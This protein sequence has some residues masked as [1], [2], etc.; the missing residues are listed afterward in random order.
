M[1]LPLGPTER[2][3]RDEVRAFVRARL[4][5]DIRAKGRDFLALKRDEAVRW[6]KILAEAGWLAP[7]WPKEAGGP[8]W[9]LLQRL[10]FDVETFREGAPR[11]NDFGVQMAGPAILHFGTPEQKAR[12][13][14]PIL[15][16]DE[17]W[18][19]G[20]SEPGA[21]SD[22]ASLRT[23]AV[24][25]G[26]HYV[27]NGSKIWTTLAHW[28]DRMICLVRTDDSGR[29]QEG[30]GF[31]LV[32]M[33]TPGVT[34][35]PIVRIHGLHEFNQV[36][37]EDARIPVADRLGEEGKG[38]TV[39]KYVLGHERVT[40]GANFGPCARFLAKLKEVAAA[41]RVDGRPLAEHPPF[42]R[43]LAE[44]ETELLGLGWSALRALGNMAADR[45]VG[46]ESSR[47]KLNS[48]RIQWDMAELLMQSTGYYAQPY[49]VRALLEGWNGAPIGPGYAIGLT[50]L[51]FDWRKMR[52]GGGG[53]DEISHEI[54]AKQTLRL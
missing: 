35:R 50:A 37:F 15:A 7:N 40:A 8:G 43:R 53:S 25:D 9:S 22:L 1:E 6:M 32:D 26:D 23:S 52:I 3:F 33:K 47:I 16:A 29:K 28:A 36:F 19:M 2:A 49:E 48:T 51:H 11:I 4:P 46:Y 42:R 24:R 41:E 34:V 38:W 45:E 30:I 5:D 12:Y 31:L 44:L 10:I 14:P 20:Y 13:V 27:V 39:A 54:I 21:G 17:L 18:C